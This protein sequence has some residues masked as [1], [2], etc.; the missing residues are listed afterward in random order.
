MVVIE[1]IKPNTEFCE[2]ENHL[3][4]TVAESDKLLA[5]SK[6]ELLKAKH[7]KRPESDELLALSEQESLKA[8]DNEIQNTNELLIFSRQEIH[9]A[10]AGKRPR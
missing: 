8:R 6:Q 4:P 5:L 2:Q 1:N 7:S 3:T 10:G 9:K